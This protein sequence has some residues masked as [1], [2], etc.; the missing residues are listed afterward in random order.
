MKKT[1]TKFEYFQYFYPYTVAIVGAKFEEKINFMSAAWHSPLSFSPPLFGVLISKKRFS[2]YIISNAKEF[3]VN[4]IPFN[5]VK[6]SAQM[7][8]K[9]GRDIDK[10][11]T[12]KIKLLPAKVISS[13]IL[14]DSYAALE[15]RLIDI[16]TYGDHDLFVG[17]VVAV[18][19]EEDAFAEENGVL[20]TK[21]IKPLLYLGSDMYITTDAKTLKHI[22]P[23]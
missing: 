21:K 1:L 2:H 15:C 18:H 13:P 16:K 7:G 3:T 23:D 10:V 5:K 8:R 17:E 22:L 11:K 9:S 12:F 14:E 19:Q 4:F 20:N 6:I